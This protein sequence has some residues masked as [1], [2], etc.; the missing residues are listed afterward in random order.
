MRL[1]SGVCSFKT[2]YL[3]SHPSHPSSLKFVDQ[4]ND[5][6]LGIQDTLQKFGTDGKIAASTLTEVSLRCSGHEVDGR[7]SRP[8][9]VP[10]LRR[11]RRGRFG[12]SSHTF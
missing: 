6:W 2:A 9:V 11:G 3:P 10:N 4:A 12:G 8:P 7:P 1:V 5:L